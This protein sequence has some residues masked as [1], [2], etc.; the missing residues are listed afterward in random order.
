[1]V[2]VGFGDP[3]ASGLSAQ[4]LSL[5]PELQSLERDGLHILFKSVKV[6]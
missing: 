4:P 5:F 6:D 2:F 3:Q 1:M